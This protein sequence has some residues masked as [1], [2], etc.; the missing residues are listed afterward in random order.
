M[1]MKTVQCRMITE[2]KNVN[3]CIYDS[4]SVR[5][6]YSIIN[7]TYEFFVLVIC[8]CVCI[9]ANGKDGK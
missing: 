3:M 1:R 5:V 6:L 8:V 4:L 2:R 7:L 9:D